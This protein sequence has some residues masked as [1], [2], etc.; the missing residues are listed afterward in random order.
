M[1]TNV[2]KIE[3]LEVGDEL[4]TMLEELAYADRLLMESSLLLGIPVEFF[5]KK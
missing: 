2:I 1:D 4:I 5:G 3:I